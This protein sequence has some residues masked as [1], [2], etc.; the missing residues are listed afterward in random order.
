M[1][2]SRGELEVYNVWFV[3]ADLDRDG[4]L[5]GHEAVWQYVA[6]D[7]PALSR[8]EFYTSMKLVSL[9]Q[10][11]GGQLDDQQALRLVNGLLGPVPLPRMAG[12]AVPRGIELPAHLMPQ[13][14]PTAAAAAAG[15]SGGPAGAP[16]TRSAAPPPAPLAF[17]PLSGE[18]AAAFQAAFS[19][20]DT[21]RDGY[22]QGGDCFG[23][24]MQSGLP[25]SVLKQIWDLVAGDEPRLSR[26]QFV[27][28]LYLIDCVK[29]GMGVPAALP[30]GP[31]PPVQGTVSMSSLSAGVPSDIYSATLVVP[32]MAARQTYH[33]QPPPTMPFASQIPGLPADRVAALEAAERARLEAEREA[34]LAREAEQRQAEQ[35]RAA[36]AAKREFF[37]RA[38]ADLR[39]TQSKVNR[40]VVEAQQRLEMEQAAAEQMEGDYNRAY[41]EFSLAHAQSAP[42]VAALEAAQAGKAA[43][44][45]KVEALRGMVAQ[46]EGFDP[47]W[48]TKEKG[49]CEALNLEIAEL[50]VRKEQLQQQAEATVAK[51]EALLAQIAALKEAA[52]GKDAEVAALT[53]QVEAVAAQGGEDREGVVRLL[54][55]VAPL[56]NRLF[57]AAKAAMVPLPAE[58]VVTMKR[59]A[60]PFLYDS[61]LGAAASDWGSFKDSGFKIVSAL[62][63]D[64]RLT[65]FAAPAA[66]ALEDQEEAAAA[67]VAPAEPAAPPAVAAAGAAGSAAP[68]AEGS[69]PAATPAADPTTAAAAGTGGK[70]LETASS[71]AE[72]EA[73]SA[74]AE[75]GVLASAI[76]EALSGAPA[77]PGSKQ[78]SLTA[79]G[80]A[81]AA[82]AAAEVRQEEAAAPA[83]G[84]VTVEAVTAASPTA[85]A[86]AAATPASLPFAVSF[87]EEEAEEAA[88]A[89]AAVVPEVAAADAFA[90]FDE[91]VGDAP[92][93]SAAAAPVPELEAA[94]APPVKQASGAFGSSVALGEGVAKPAAPR[95]AALDPAAEGGDGDGDG[96]NAEEPAAAPP[97]GSWTAF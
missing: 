77:K 78:G 75:A 63:V 56:Y 19:Q 11:N 53:E 67:A 97:A 73:V 61:L 18:Q 5:S 70:G 88:V 62:P 47:E 66:A 24:F 51:R 50:T 39:L 40:V 48:E 1:A 4:V 59:E 9:A 72:A 92:A 89:A 41:A 86:A 26:H 81:A 49:E 13:E 33:P 64:T 3:A 14:P 23:A 52:S 20:L 65:T 46:L 79:G 36:A 68:A 2:E 27:Q 74:A 28:A 55:Q 54:K 8:Q 34:A 95:G 93:A 17:P 94:P 12:M 29:R 90:A 15:S 45:G 21:D 91:V 60:S 71:T 30:P 6:G 7:R 37:T 16:A 38:L 42:L 85:A 22:V 80:G 83:A 31:F 96:G 84:R 32:P 43:L 87:D 57:D 25:K 10:L 82:E 35:D 69:K 76:A 58:A 44:A